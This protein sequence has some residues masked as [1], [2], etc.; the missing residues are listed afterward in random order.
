VASLGEVCIKGEIEFETILFKRGVDLLKFI[1]FEMNVVRFL[2]F[3][4]VTIPLAQL[5]LSFK[6]RVQQQHMSHH[7]H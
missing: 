6:E 5:E 1:I 2:L 4:R 7:A 3:V